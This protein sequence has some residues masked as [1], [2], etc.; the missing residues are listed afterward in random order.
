MQ[1]MVHPVIFFHTVLNLRV[2]QIWDRLR[3]AIRPNRLFSLEADSNSMWSLRGVGRPVLPSAPSRDRRYGNSF[4]LLNQCVCSTS[5]DLWRPRGQSRLWEYHL[6]YFEFLFSTPQHDDLQLVLDWIEKNP[7]MET[8][9][10]DPYP[11]SMRIRAWLEWLVRTFP[12]LSSS[13][14]KT[15]LESISVQAE[16]L[17]RSFEYHLLGN[18]LLENAITLTWAGLRIQGTGAEHWLQKGLKVLGHELQQQVLADGVHEE[19]SPAYHG[20]L[21]HGLSRLARVG[22]TVGTPEGRR[23]A[24]VCENAVKEMLLAYADLTHPDGFVALVNDSGLSWAPKVED[25]ADDTL[26]SF[27]REQHRIWERPVAGY[28]GWRSEKNYFIFDA[29]PVGP[30][31]QPGHGHA[32]ALSFE[33]SLNG[34]RV[35][36]DTGSVTYDV[37]TARAWDRGTGAHNTVQVNGGDQ[38]EL[39]ASF[40]CGRRPKV[41]GF[42]DSDPSNI[43]RTS[44]LGKAQ[45]KTLSSGAYLHERKVSMARNSLFFTDRISCRRSG[46]VVMR[47]HV[48]PGIDVELSRARQEAILRKSGK[49]IAVLGGIPESWRLISTPYHPDFNL[50]YERPCLVLDLENVEEANWSWWIKWDGDMRGL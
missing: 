40:R 9:G 36:T 50:E 14:R 20:L 22:Q 10:W 4:E 37:C 46:R 1:N 39:W 28:F 30:D 31:H 43:E 33:L 23:V 11:L 19:R 24:A 44:F 26:S 32:D 35:L 8:S 17:S 15:I 21:C 48:A 2:V 16:V 42:V 38:C 6:H 7:P 18:H 27:I 45:V 13:E 3:R 12:S 5:S 49:R 25:V 47:L 41:E 34:E 29:G